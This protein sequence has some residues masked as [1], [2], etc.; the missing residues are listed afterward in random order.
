[1][2]LAI[3]CK[4]TKNANYSFITSQTQPVLDKSEILDIFDNI[5]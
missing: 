2:L 3:V 4:C 5:E 1:M